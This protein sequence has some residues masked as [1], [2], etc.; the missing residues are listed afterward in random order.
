MSFYL[1]LF[2]L[3]I[4]VLRIERYSSIDKVKEA[5]DKLESKW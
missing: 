3:A 5:Y 1:I 2:V 4:A